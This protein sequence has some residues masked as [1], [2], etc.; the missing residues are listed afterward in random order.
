MKYSSSMMLWLLV[1]GHAWAQEAP[2]A[3]ASAVAA[4]AK[5]ADEVAASSAAKASAS[6][7]PARKP[8]EKAAAN[9]TDHLSLDTTTVTGN[10]ELPKVMY[11]VPWKKAELGQLPG[12][13]FNSLLNDVLQPVDREVFRREV[14]YYQVVSGK[15][16]SGGGA[17]TQAT[18]SAD[19]R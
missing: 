7:A 2:P 17:A 12:Q 5:P 9:S 3:A 19:G 15:D 1:A 6:K 4:Q 11:I 8:D 10:K 18:S 13:P 16:H 14:S